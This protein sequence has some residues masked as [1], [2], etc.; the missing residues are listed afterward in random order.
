MS[1]IPTKNPSALIAYYTAVFSL[2]PCFALLL[3]PVAILLGTIGLKKAKINPDISGTVHA[4]IGIALG[5]STFL[6]NVLFILYVMF[7]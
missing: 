5:S 7:A 2:L 3:G 4:W 1:I 6:I